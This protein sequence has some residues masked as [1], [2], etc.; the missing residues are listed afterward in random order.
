METSAE[1]CHEHLTAE[2]KKITTQIR[3]VA[4]TL[5]EKVDLDKPTVEFLHEHFYKDPTLALAYYYCCSADPRVTKF[6][7]ELKADV[8]TSVIWDCISNL[9][10]NPIGQE[11]AM[12]CQEYSMNLTNHTQELLP[13][14]CASC[15]KCLLSTNGQQEIVE[16]KIDDLSSEFLLTESQIECLTTLP[17][18]IV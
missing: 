8:D 6:N 17:H 14:A 5:N 16:M 10:G 4:A 18:D 1:Q 3:S 2:E 11:E 9:I 12:S 7:D 13:A 15:C